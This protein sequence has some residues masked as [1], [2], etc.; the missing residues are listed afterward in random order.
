MVVPTGK[1]LPGGGTHTSVGG[2]LH[3]PLAVVV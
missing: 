2:G 3:P 1:K